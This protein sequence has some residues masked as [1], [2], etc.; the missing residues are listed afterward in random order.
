M[1]I[2]THIPTID[3]RSDLGAAVYQLVLRELRSHQISYIW[4]EQYRVRLATADDRTGSV[5]LLV[6]WDVSAVAQKTSQPKNYSTPVHT[7]PAAY[8]SLTL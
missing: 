3:R 5:D 6:N 8:R 2:P 4:P 1:T 7:E